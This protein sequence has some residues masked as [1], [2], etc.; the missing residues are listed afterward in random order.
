MTEL[1]PVHVVDDDDALR[2]SLVFLLSSASIP[3]V[4]HESA[5]SLIAALPGLDFACIITDVRMPGMT[6]IDLLRHLHAIDKQLPVI[7]VTGHSDVPLAVEALKAGAFDFIEKPFEDERI[8][9]AVRSALEFRSK[10][11]RAHE[12]RAVAMGRVELLTARERQVF[13]GLVAG[14]PNKII[15]HELGISPRTVEIYRANVMSKLNAS[16]LSDVV[17]IALAADIDSTGLA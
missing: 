8:I 14:H 17:R 6:G 2:D 4:P 9:A 7:V 13:E 16:S 5:E 11:Q 3:A 12:S 1:G 15:A 10:T